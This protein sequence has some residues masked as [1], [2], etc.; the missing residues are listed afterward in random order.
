MKTPSSSSSLPKLLQWLIAVVCLV[1][2]T[3]IV[4]LLLAG[5]KADSILIVG[6]LVSSLALLPGI[7]F[8]AFGELAR[9]LGRCLGSL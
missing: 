9:G 2:G 8:G 6:V 4:A 5:G 3:V 7:L 1:V